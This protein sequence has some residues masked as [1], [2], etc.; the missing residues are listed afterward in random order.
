MRRLLLPGVA[1]G[2][3]LVPTATAW[4]D[5]ARSLT[6][7]RFDYRA[8]P[9]RVIVLGFDGVDPD[10]VREYMDRLPAV[11]ALAR[12]GV[13]LPCRTTDPPESP[14]AWATFATG[15]NPGKTGIYDFVRRD[16]RAEDPYRPLNSM[17][18]K[19]PP[20]FGPFGVPLRP[21]AAINLRGGESFW[22]PVARAGFKVSVLRMP[23][24]FP[25]T[26][27]RGGELLSGLGVPDLRGTNGSYT[28]FRAGRDATE[29]HTV[30]GGRHVKIYPRMGAA[31]ARLD[32]PPDPR[33][34]GSG[35]V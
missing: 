35:Q 11:A 20:L 16:P 13:F 3:L 29:G 32:G 18:D 10:L 19:R 8:S 31:E 15:A 22:D 17:V 25:P 21:P 9:R 1:L 12:D 26:L 33:A 5:A 34:P 23:L 24:T 14:V 7:F 28:L 27:A 2:L 4:L 30:F 6:G